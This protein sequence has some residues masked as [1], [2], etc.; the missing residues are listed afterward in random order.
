LKAALLRSLCFLIF[1]NSLGSFSQEWKRLK[2]YQKETGNLIL[3]EGYWLKKDRKNQTKVW[4][5]ANRFN[6]EN[7]AYLKY[8]TIQQIR[9]F[10]LFIKIELDNK[11]DEIKWVHAAYIIANELSKTEISFIRFTIVRNN[12]VIEFAQ[13][14]SQKVFEYSFPK[15]KELYFSKEPLKGNEAKNWDKNQAI[16]EQCEILDPL[17]KKLS[18]KALKKL[19]NMAKGKGIYNLGVIKDIRYDGDINNCNTRY[20]YSMNKLIPFCNSIK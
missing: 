19:E 9:D 4:E 11:G 17:Y 14:G 3:K 7:D 13:E 12:E 1:I 2:T 16:I 6:L 18:I 5:N 20:N 8:K 15:L 10:Y